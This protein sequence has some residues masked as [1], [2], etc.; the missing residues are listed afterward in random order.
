VAAKLDYYELLGVSRGADAVELKRAY[1]EL[2]MRWHPD[3]NPGDRAA[4][5]K[6][7]QV[8][9]AYAVLSD[10]EKRARYDRVGHAGGFDVADFGL[11]SFT[12]LFEGLFGDLFGKKKRDKAPGRDLR[13]TLELEFAE[14]ALG[15]ERTITFTSK[16]EC[17]DCQ[18]TGARG[19]PA[20]LGPCGACAGRGEIKMQ[21][22]FFSLGK[23]C[24]TCSGT[25]KV[26]ADPC[27]T[28]KAAGMVEKERQYTVSI[29]PGIED[30]GV[31]RVAG[32]G[33][34]G[35]RG[36][37]PGDLN[38]AV[39]VKAHP[40]FRREGQV[41]V[42]EVPVTL[43]EAALGSVVEVPTLDGKVEMR[44]PPGTQS[45]TVF[46]LRQKGLPVGLKGS[47]RGDTHVRVIVE[48]PSQ[49]APEERALVEQLAGALRAEA[50]PQR[51]KFRAT[52]KELYGG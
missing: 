41:V 20:G 15:C 23:T 51:Q 30:G 35:R 25:G 22:G 48:T 21:Q 4:E 16:V 14:A 2:A 40:L 37:P 9:E 36:G 45:G 33:E 6:F 39:K 28:C 52:M 38:V 1:R 24:T 19:G 27:P 44:V 12:E 7:K 10:P 34:P 17:A 50:S 5:D 29:P 43:V 46:R 8:S 49:L 18:A 47:P 11:P 26:V 31:R 42:C 3:K 32:Q 13:Y